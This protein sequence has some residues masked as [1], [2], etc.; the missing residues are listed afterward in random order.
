M[1][2]CFYVPENIKR[3]VMNLKQIHSQQCS[4]LRFGSQRKF[5]NLVFSRLR[6]FE[7]PQ[8]DRDSCPVKT[9]YD[10]AGFLPGDDILERYGFFRISPDLIECCHCRLVPVSL[11]AP[12][13]VL[14][15]PMKQEN[16]SSHREQCKGSGLYLRRLSDALSRIMDSN[17]S[18]TYKELENDYFK[19]IVKEL[20][21]CSA[22]DVFT[23][24]VTKL[25]R[26]MRGEL[27][28]S[29]FEGG[30]S[31]GEVAFQGQPNFKLLSDLFRIWADPIDGVDKSLQS[32]KEFL[33]YFQLISPGVYLPERGDVE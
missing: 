14:T 22:V 2:K 27:A 9:E 28:E 25:V 12:F 19:K 15:A 26:Q 13:A 33:R 17:I 10:N 23:S 11:R 4:N 21:G 32:N 20:V 6:A 31:N 16:V 7:V 8:L 1:L 30:P 24:G 29:L 3:A 5:F 18:I